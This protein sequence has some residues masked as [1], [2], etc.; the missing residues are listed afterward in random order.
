MAN[1]LTLASRVQSVD[2]IRQISR[3]FSL[4]PFILA[5]KLYLLLWFLWFA[6]RDPLSSVSPAA[7]LL[8]PGIDLAVCGAIAIAYASFYAFAKLVFGRFGGGLAFAATLAVHIVMVLFTV[9]SMKINTVYGVP[10]DVEHIRSAGDLAV[11]RSSM[12]AYADAASLLLASLGIVGFWVFTPFIER[13]FS[14]LILRRHGYRIL[15]ALAMA[16]VVYAGATYFQFQ[17]VYT[18]GLKKNAAFAFAR[19]YRPVPEGADLDRLM[20]NLGARLSQDAERLWRE[21]S[22]QG[23]VLS[24]RPGHAWAEGIAQDL[25]VLIILLESTSSVHLD[26]E[27]TPNIVSLVHHGLR[28]ENFFTTA[29]H[30]YAAAYAI[31]YSDYAGIMS[32]RNVYAEQMPHTS[33]FEVFH[34]S[35]YATAFFQSG[36]LRYADYGYLLEDKGVDTL[37]GAQ[38]TLFNGG[39]TGWTWGA[40]EE[41]TVAALSD[42]IKSN[43]NDKFFAIYRPVFPHHPYYTP[44]DPPPFPEESW[45]DRH[46]NALHYVDNNVG[47]L[48]SA[49]DDLGLRDDTLVIL[50]SDHGETVSS[51]PVGHGLHMSN[52][53]LRVPLLF[54]N[55]KLFPEAHVSERVGNHIDFAPTV[56]ALAG[57]A[58]DEDWRGR[59]LLAEQFSTRL[60]YVMA[61]HAHTDALIDGDLLFSFNA[62][63]GTGELHEQSKTG[64]SPLS[65]DDSRRSLLK[66]YSEVT[67]AVRIWSTWQHLRRA[68]REREQSGNDQLFKALQ[69]PTGE[70]D[71]GADRS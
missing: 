15:G 21:P 22:L 12:W 44:R 46:R 24:T 32:L 39:G 6:G 52:E 48:L 2:L 29:S 60:L 36:F 14:K 16:I 34:R 61:N 53:E 38:T 56:A 26:A 50:T 18:S 13:T 54:S 23:E 66:R 8:L 71:A 57:L 41:S 5:T 19:R 35:G 10:L 20:E 28:F 33:L 59:N 11:M 65:Q 42:W 4:F 45:R 58:P 1:V 70:R 69:A 68:R 51:Y 49:L 64:F 63:S 40:F 17:G 31:F 30:S 55:R 27:T 9:V 7:A 43:R 25:N 67:E 37:V 47:R 62:A 3:G